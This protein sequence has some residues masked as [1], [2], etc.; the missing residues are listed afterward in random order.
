MVRPR[1]HNIS[2]KSLSGTYQT[3]L[4]NGIM[5]QQRID[6]FSNHISRRYVGQKSLARSLVQ[7]LGAVGRIQA[8]E[9]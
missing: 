9:S 6:V 8:S 4:A 5:S 3:P 7:P 2:D 1:R